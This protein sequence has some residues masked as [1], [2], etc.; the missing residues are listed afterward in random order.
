MQVNRMQSNNNPSFNA[1]L[2]IKDVPG[3][4]EKTDIDFL[5][6][7][8]AK[9]GTKKDSIKIKLD[10]YEYGDKFTWSEQGLGWMTDKEMD[11]VEVNVK[12]II[13]KK[14]KATE[15]FCCYGHYSEDVTEDVVR[16]IMICLEEFA[17]KLK[18]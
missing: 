4:L 14:D 3:V 12:S 16:S 5:R 10:N 7:E 2:K 17:D 18:K 6:K 9:I 13:N 1:R 15:D 8:A 11:S